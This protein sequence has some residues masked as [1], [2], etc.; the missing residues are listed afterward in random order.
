MD[1]NSPPFTVW[2]RSA[3]RIARTAGALLAALLLW[4]LPETAARAD[5]CPADYTL[6]HYPCDQWDYAQCVWVSAD[7]SCNSPHIWSEDS[8]SCVIDCSV[9]NY[10]ISHGAC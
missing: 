1:R 10:Q 6:S 2:A 4:A 9:P 3:G 8:C 7:R 5:D